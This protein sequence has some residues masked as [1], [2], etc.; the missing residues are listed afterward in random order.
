MSISIQSCWQF[1]MGMVFHGEGLTSQAETIPTFS[2]S[3]G[4]DEDL[5]RH[6][7][8][9][10]GTAG[11][12]S[13]SVVGQ[14]ES[15]HSITQPLPPPPAPLPSTVSAGANL[16]P[17]S[18]GGYYWPL[19]S[20]FH[21][22]HQA[23]KHCQQY[24]PGMNT[25]ETTERLSL[26]QQPGYC[27]WRWSGVTNSPDNSGAVGRQAS[28]GAKQPWCTTNHHVYSFAVSPQDIPTKNEPTLNAT[29]LPT[30]R[31][32]E[33]SKRPTTRN[34]GGR[35]KIKTTSQEIATRETGAEEREENG[36]ASPCG[37]ILQAAASQQQRR[38]P[39]DGKVN[40]SPPCRGPFLVD[41]SHTP[42]AVVC[43]KCNMVTPQSVNTNCASPGVVGASPTTMCVCEFTCTRSA[44]LSVSLDDI[45]TKSLE[46]SE[47]Q[48]SAP[49]II[50]A[51][52]VGA[53]GEST[54]G[55]SS[56]S[57]QTLPF[58]PKQLHHQSEMS[59]WASGSP[60]SSS[61]NVTTNNINSNTSPCFPGAHEISS[62]EK[63]I[64]HQTDW[65]ESYKPEAPPLPPKSTLT[66]LDW[67]LSEGSG[68]E[69][70]DKLTNQWFEGVPPQMSI[71]S[72]RRAGVGCSGN[73]GQIQL[74]QFLLDELHDP[75]SARYICWTGH[76]AEFKLKDP[77]EVA[78]RWGLRK[79]KPKMNYEKLS[80]GLRYY[81]DKKIIE[82]S[83]GKRYVYRFSPKIE[84]L[85]KR[86]PGSTNSGNSKNNETG[87]A[88]A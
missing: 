24:Q 88:S 6:T 18:I 73:G 23:F 82:K 69:H 5:R 12:F 1:D 20:A 47:R 75:L 71:G 63:Y 85:I 51:S 56:T 43:W 45:F 54:M 9:L 26:P 13:P 7:A 10:P 11:W 14:S 33:R 58:T 55:L 67:M 21:H 60:L 32:N 81:Y 40:P 65:E 46:S 22:Q 19:N 49:P 35:L 31:R 62:S 29:Q 16:Y 87:D 37:V 8:N 39:F 57:L 34:T 83:A 72:F 2:H 36:C 17:D 4:D 50:G 38:K 59:S 80:R 70:E 84:E 64:C 3:M 66:S 61:A 30:H 52:Q 48:A 41:P 78:R 28:A 77:N 86:A 76:G 53:Y 42:N 74:W 25:F 15:Q 79:N 27:D 44:P 68:V